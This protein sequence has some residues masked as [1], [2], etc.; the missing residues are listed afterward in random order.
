MSSKPYPRWA[1]ISL[2]LGGAALVFGLLTAIG[3]HWATG[4][5]FAV[6]GSCLDLIGVIGL[7]FFAQTSD[8]SRATLQRSESHRTRALRLV[9][10]LGMVAIGLMIA[11]IVIA[12]VTT[13]SP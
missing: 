10:V 11:S 8:V 13:A 5:V 9:L 1:F 4:W 6:A 12:V 3:G 2:V 7:R